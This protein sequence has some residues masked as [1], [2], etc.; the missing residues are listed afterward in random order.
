LREQADQIGVAPGAG[1]RP[2]AW[3]SPMLECDIV[4]KGGITSGVVYPGA[5]VAL[6]KWYTFKSIG[7]ASAGAIAAAGVA[8][9]EYGRTSGGGFARLAQVPHE[10]SAT[11]AHGNPFLLQLFRPEDTTKPLFDTGFGFL[12]FGIVRGVLQL[13]RSFPLGP[14]VAVSL[15]AVGVLLAMFG[16]VPWWLAVLIVAIAPWVLVGLLVRD[17]L[18]SLNMIPGN[19]FGLCRLGPAPAGVSSPLTEWLHG[20]IQEAAGRPLDKPLTFADLWGL[21]PLTGEETPEQLE[22]RKEQLKRLA[23]ATGE[24][25][26]DLQVM[27]TNLTNGRPMR[28]PIARDRYRD[29]AEDGGGLLFDPS[30]WAHFFPPEVVEHMVARSP[31]MDQRFAD[32][33]AKVAPDREL[34]LFPGTGE[35]PVV[36]AAR[37]SLSFPILISTIPLW[38][39]R[40]RGAGQTPRLMHVVFS[41]GGISSNFPVHFF[42]APLPTRPTF[43]L[44]LGGFAKDE[45]PD[46][47]VPSQNV[48]DPPAP[49]EQAPES[50]TEIDSLFAFAVSIKDAMENW[51]DNTQ[52]RLP[53]FRERIIDIKLAHGEGGLNLAMDE[54]KIKRLTDRGEYAGERLK[55]FFSGVGAKPEWTA[56]WN[57]SRFTRFRVT[58]SVIEQALRAIGRG[59]NAP[60]DAATMPYPDRI[61][62]GG[63]APY[64]LTPPQLLAFAEATIKGYDDLV[65]GWGANTL[66]DPDVPHP[67][68]VLR[69]TPPV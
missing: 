13:L 7:G 5:V 36:A 29:T 34:H 15:A 19:D 56:H 63:V 17:L 10:L 3:G 58:M 48:V 45:H 27:T 4:M 50:W 32:D 69:L 16:V 55:A 11:D 47:N 39:L 2:S 37:M 53:G 30:E 60:V 38:R 49:N 1:E 42:D 8:A 12:R 65:S 68:A 67:T 18:K 9:A 6:A 31:A 23:W 43:A 54:A 41:D 21:P 20:V 24:R 64:A 22:Q 25:K 61:A 51:R 66:T 40:Y 35:L 57:D 46:P 33:L 44:N 52:G 28:L 14:I 26:L 62:A 59:Y